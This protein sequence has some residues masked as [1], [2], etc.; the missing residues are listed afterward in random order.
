MAREQQSKSESRHRYQMSLAFLLVENQGQAFLGVGVR[1]SCA[2]LV[3]YL[4]N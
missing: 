2:N 4:G 3:P 1:L